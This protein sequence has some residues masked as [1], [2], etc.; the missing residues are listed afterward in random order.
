MQECRQK[1]QD[2][3]DENKKLTNHIVKIE[4]DLKV[5]LRF[6]S[7]HEAVQILGL[8]VCLLFVR[9]RKK[10]RN[11]SNMKQMKFANKMMTWNMM[12]KFLLILSEMLWLVAKLRYRPFTLCHYFCIV[13]NFR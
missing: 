1:S 6:M 11:M 9:M 12:L 5:M 7:K 10:L 2:L 8:I 13:G 3:E 4:H